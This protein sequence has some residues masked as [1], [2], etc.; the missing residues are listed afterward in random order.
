VCAS[1]VDLDLIPY[2]ADAR[3]AA[4]AAEPGVG[5]VGLVVATPSRDRLRVIGELADRLGHSVEFA[6]ID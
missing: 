3:L 6:S 4:L 1:G 2:A 5:G